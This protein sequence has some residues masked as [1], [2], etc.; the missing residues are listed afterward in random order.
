MV[1]FVNIAGQLLSIWPS[2]LMLWLELVLKIGKTLV[3]P[4]DSVEE[5][6][7]FLPW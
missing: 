1:G 7:D 6:K 4:W 5:I 2:L 3:A